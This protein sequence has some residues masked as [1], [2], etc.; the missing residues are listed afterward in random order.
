M[1][2]T[3]KASQVLKEKGN[4]NPTTLHKLLYKSVPKRDGG[5]RFIP[6]DEIDY[7]LVVV[8]EVSMVPGSIWNLLLSHDV[9]VIAL[10]DPEQLPPVSKE[11]H[12][13]VLNHPHVFLDEIMRQA[14]ESEIIRLSM[15]IREGRTLASY[16][17]SNEEVMIVKSADEG[18]FRWADQILCATNAT[19]NKLNNQYRKMLRYGKEPQAG[20]KIIGLS[21]HW[22]FDSIDNDPAPLTNGTIGTIID[23]E[24]DYIS[25][26]NRITPNPVPILMTSMRT[27]DGHNF[28]NIPIDYSSIKTGAPYFSDSQKGKIRTSK[29]MPEIPYDFAYGYCITV[30]KYQG[31]QANKILLFEEEHPWERIEHRK[32]L[33]TGITRAAEKIVIVKKS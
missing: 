10:G 8:D 29:G 22:D 18:M 13:E 4:P 20:D 21:N 5:Y 24:R 17:G 2:Y 9:H 27:E 26:P 30:W 7:S 12:Q 15:W 16:K 3:G 6:K 33:Y 1:A 23:Y 28:I 25:F 14:Q 19:R 31:S 11:D 32:Y